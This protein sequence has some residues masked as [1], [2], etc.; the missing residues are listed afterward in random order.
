MNEDNKKRMKNFAEV[1]TLIIWGLL[2]G[3]TCFGVWNFNPEGF[4]RWCTLALGVCNMIAIVK[5]AKKL[6]DARNAKRKKK[7]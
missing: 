7:Q 5:G 4:V 1:W 6:V 3:I 2:T